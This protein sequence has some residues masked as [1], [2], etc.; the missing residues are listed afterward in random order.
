MEESQIGVNHDDSV[1]DAS[2]DDLLVVVGS[3]RSGNVSNA[4]FT[5]SVDVV[6]ERE[7]SVAGQSNVVQLAE[8]FTTL[9]LFQQ[10]ERER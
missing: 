9:D 4:T 5:S 7:E 6:S 2:I 1:L 10:E 8:P 3:G